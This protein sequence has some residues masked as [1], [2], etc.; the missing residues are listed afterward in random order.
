MTVDETRSAAERIERPAPPGSPTDMVRLRGG[1]GVLVHAEMPSILVL[2]SSGGA[3]TTTTALGVAAAIATAPVAAEG[4]VSPVVVDASP[5]G[6]D[7]KERG[8]D[9]AVPAGTVQTWLTMQ[10]RSARADAVNRLRP[11]L[12]WLDTNYSQHHI[13]DAVIVV[14]RQSR[15][16]GP[17]VAA[18]AREHLGG[19]V[20]GVVEI[21]FDL[22]LAIG[23]RITW[24]KLAHSTRSAYRNVVDLLH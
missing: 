16:D 6:G 19:F 21:P 20:R 18:H 11:A 3:G 14:T 22:H 8:C 5:C 10:H 2:G 13:A 24:D 1:S 7:I 15:A 4:F 9:T 12:A 23:G 17:N